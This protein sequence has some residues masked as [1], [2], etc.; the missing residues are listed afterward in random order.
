[1]DDSPGSDA[2]D[3][4]P[5]TSPNIIHQTPE[6]FH[7]DRPSNRRT[8]DEFSDG[9]EP[10]SREA[11]GQY[12][13][14]DQPS[15]QHTSQSTTL[16]TVQ[17]LTL[18]IWHIITA[19]VTIS[20]DIVVAYKRRRNS[21]PP[22]RRSPRN[23]PSRSRIFHQN[24]PTVDGFASTTP[25]KSRTIR[26]RPVIG[27]TATIANAVSANVGEFDFTSEHVMSGA[28]HPLGSE[29]LVIT[30]DRQFEGSPRSL[31]I[32][33]MPGT[34]P[35]SPLQTPNQNAAPL[36]NL[37][38][39]PDAAIQPEETTVPRQLSTDAEAE[40]AILPVEAVSSPQFSDQEDEDDAAEAR[41]MEA[42]QQHLR[43]IGSPK[44]EDSWGVR[45]I[46]MIRAAMLASPG[47]SP[48]SSISPN[49]V[50][51]PKKLKSTAPPKSILRSGRFGLA[52]PLPKNSSCL[53]GISK[54][55]DRLAVVL[56]RKAKCP[57]PE[58]LGSPARLGRSVAFA[59]S[60]RTGR[61]VTKVKKY[62][63][64][65]SMNYPS[66]SS[67]RDESSIL[68]SPSVL[69]ASARGLDTSPTIVEQV[70]HTPMTDDQ[71]ASLQ[72]NNEYYQSLQRQTQQAAIASSGSSL[73][74]NNPHSSLQHAQTDVTDASKMSET[75]ALEA[76]TDAD[77]LM[78]GIQDSE[79]AKSSHSPGSSSSQP[80]GQH[81]LSPA[82]SQPVDTTADNALFDNISPVSDAPVQESERI[83]NSEHPS[84]PSNEAYSTF[85]YQAMDTNATT[86]LDN[87]S[88]PLPDEQA[89]DPEI[90]SDSDSPRLSKP[91][92][93]LSPDQQ[94]AAPGATA[95]S[96]SPSTAHR[97][98]QAFDS[99]SN[100]DSLSLSSRLDSAAE[101][102]SDQQVS[103]SANADT[104]TNNLAS[105]L[106]GT[107][108]LS[109]ESVNNS[110]SLSLQTNVE[111]VLSSDHNVSTA[112]A[113]TESRRRSPPPS[114][115]QGM[116]S[117]LVNNSLSLASQAN[118]REECSLDSGTEQLGQRS[119]G[120]RK[121][122]DDDVFIAVTEDNPPSLPTQSGVRSKSPDLP[123][124]VAGLVITPRKSDLDTSGR[125]SSERKKRRSEAKA[126]E[127]A[128]FAKEAA[129]AEAQL[130]REA[131][132]Q[133]FR[134]GLRRIPREKV[135]LP[136]TPEAD[137]L[138]TEALKKGPNAQVAFTSTGNPITRR[139][140]GKVLPQRGTTDDPSG[141]LNDEIIAA[142][143]QMVTDCAHE[144]A[145]HKRNDTPKFHSFNPFFYTNLKKKG[146]EGV[147]RWSK[148]AKIGGKDLE[149]VEWVFIPVNDAGNHWTMVIVSPKRKTM[150]Y[151]DSM[152]HASAPVL[153][154]IKAWL[155]GELGSAYNEAEWTIREQAGLEGLGG[156]PSQD[157]AKDCGVFAVTSAKM[158]ALGVDP[159][160]VSAGDMPMQRRRMVAEVLNGGF[161]GAFEPTIEFD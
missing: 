1:M 26:P 32:R 69:T 100:S 12:D 49:P 71:G 60:P 139:D 128:R 142:Y 90:I 45:E 123:T 138:V 116:S 87:S 108:R 37:P 153:K 17:W 117:E 132:E 62:V 66:P 36:F 161:S 121:E 18:C 150:E 19:A 103:S 97:H 114:D 86:G 27:N 119:M 127:Q 106:Q 126:K 129:E 68:S 122:G 29:S 149:K 98:L 115:T 78:S 35:D 143:L 38:S 54:F 48:L 148:K 101:P 88:S 2:M 84:S 41:C 52:T 157:N 104:N 10:L 8:F 51:L 85:E 135:I 47:R 92:I 50:A 137:E 11:T 124:A 147:K 75:A 3:W 77:A 134:D 63:I 14:A 73:S 20:N 152:H 61:P 158:V 72:L 23:S 160:A 39:K 159:M 24:A 155:K 109:F 151:L 105:P 107:Q 58:I 30:P 89:P 133:A 55:T 6:P 44:E 21:P 94:P 99:E 81:A 102:S 33:E 110:S 82:E 91:E 111:H 154:H 56:G 146:Y 112:T 34:Y 59:E 140:I 125:R 83:S 7:T 130:K 136:L 144:R 53:R 93:A 43:R 22:S 96:E 40:T 70:P 13:T 64:G 9:S 141:W 131:N 76:T 113:D 120:L 95:V 42:Y 46:K 74:S 67:S 5:D 15:A 31:R 79:S 4:T 25:L 16:R 28:L 80:S 65:E 145:G 57:S 118:S 156:G